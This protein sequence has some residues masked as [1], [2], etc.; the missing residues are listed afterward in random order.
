[1]NDSLYRLLEYKLH[2]ITGIYICNN[3]QSLPL[4]LPETAKDYVLI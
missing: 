2:F 4:T 1:M 3:T